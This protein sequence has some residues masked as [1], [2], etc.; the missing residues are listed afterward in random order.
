MWTF[1]DIVMFSFGFAVSW[2][3]KDRIV[4]TVSGA[5]ALAKALESKAA[6]LRAAL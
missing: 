2:F 5:E 4:Q 1:F 6:A 3:S